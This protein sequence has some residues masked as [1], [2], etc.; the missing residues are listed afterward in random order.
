[1]R[2]EIV[3]PT[4]G[5]SYYFGGD[6]IKAQVIV[7]CGSS[8]R[9]TRSLFVDIYGRIDTMVCGVCVPGCVCVWAGGASTRVLSQFVLHRTHT[10]YTLSL[11]SIPSHTHPLPHSAS[12]APSP[13]LRFPPIV[14]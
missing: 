5:P 10:T 2:V 4:D 9:I 12:L 6:L 8:P 13:L 3:L 7:D 11:L 14:H 1:M